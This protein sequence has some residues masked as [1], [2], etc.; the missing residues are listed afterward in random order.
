MRR[1]V[2][3]AVVGLA[4]LGAV[5]CESTQ[6]RSARLSKELGDQRTIEKGLKVKKLDRDI[7]VDATDVITDA[8]GTVVIATLRSRAPGPLASVPLALDVVDAKGGSVYKNNAPGLDRSLTSAVL[9][10]PG[11]NQYWIN[12]QVVAVGE[13]KS[14]EVRAG[15]GGAPVKGKLP[16]IDAP[17]PVL[18]NDATS[19]LAAT[20]RVVNKSDIEQRDLI[21]NVLARSGGRIVAA[22]RAVV[23]KLRPGKDAKYQAFLIGK[24]AEDAQLEASAPPTRLK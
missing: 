9:L 5:G 23:R 11:R 8:N 19:G 4:A 7:E 18:E 22:G 15:V 24:P 16:V 10:E 3:A 21:V 2:F 14:A 17:P 1:V 12:D 20:G 6:S 13:P